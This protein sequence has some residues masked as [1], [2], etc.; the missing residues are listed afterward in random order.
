MAR[1]FYHRY[2]GFFIF[3]GLGLFCVPAL[4]QQD[5]ASKPINLD[6]ALEDQ[7]PQDLVASYYHYA[8]AKWY[9]NEGDYPKSLS[10]MQ[11]ALK[12]N[13]NSSTIHVGMAAMLYER[14]GSTSEAIEHARE[15]VR[16]D[17]QN[18][19]A[20]WFLVNAYFRTKERGADPKEGM[21]KAVQEL[22]KLKELTPEDETVYYNLGGAYFELNQPEKAIEAFEKYQSVSGNSDAGYRE[23]AK[24]YDR[25]G[26]PEKAIEYLSKGLEVQ[27]DSAES[28]M[29]LGRIFSRLNRSKEAVPVY[30]KLLEVT[31]NNI[32]VSRQLANSLFNAG[33]YK[34]AIVILKN[35][36]ETAPADRASQILLGRAQIMS[37][38]YAE[39]VKTLQAIAT[40][41]P[42]DIEAQF[43]LGKAYEESG[44][45]ADAAALF[46]RLLSKSTPGSEE[47][48]ANRLVFQ[49]HLADDYV[50]LKEY[51]KAIALYE[52]IVKT[53]PNTNLRL[54]NAYRL[55]RK[56][57]KAIPLGKRMVE[58]DPDDIQLLVIYARTLADA[59][60]AK[61]GA[62]TLSKQYEKAP[63]NI[64][65]AVN[66][67][68]ILAEAGKSKD[69][70]EI[71]SRAI[72]ANPQNTDLHIA[73]SD[74]YLLDKRFADAE[75][76]LRKAETKDLDNETLERLKFH[77]AAVYEKQKDF[78]RAESLFKE[79]LKSN[80][81]NATVLN[82]LG[83]MLADRGVRLEEAVRYV[84]EALVLDPQN[85]A[86]LDSLGWAYFKMNDLVNAEKYLV[87]AGGFVKD[88]PTIEDHLGDLYFKMGNLQKARDYWERSIRI[89]TEQ[90]DIQ[91]VRRKLESLQ[92]TLRKQKSPK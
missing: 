15:A 17:A 26:N 44:K 21:L 1:R 24:Y 19:D 84:K 45:F 72:Q 43:W 79:I 18:P 77:R 76:I 12:Y 63:D 58:K 81:R 92:E 38:E 9:E 88:D 90:E 54:L 78:D 36:A 60:N 30:Q 61:E 2:K 87:E 53:D 4:A 51:D 32:S 59:G 66:Y 42:R 74:L 57:D 6:R 37:G 75:K 49:Q 29:V 73:L 3:I 56:F 8:L 55:S 46:S 70:A 69:G 62:E 13:P 91:K 71:L 7:V 5:P 41:D 67:A 34:D 47:L 11:T 64:Q 31:G 83:Y 27:P 28:L 23:I 50:E 10:E 68:R 52:E 82:Y 39:A 35:L 25:G 48:N 20:H 16:L 33:E 89:G 85:G 22:E 14:I 86:Y 40:E 80:P 65:V